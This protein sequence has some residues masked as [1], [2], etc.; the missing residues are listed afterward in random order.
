VAPRREGVEVHLSSKEKLQGRL[1]FN[2]KEGLFDH[3]TPGIP[4]S[5]ELCSTPKS[6]AGTDTTED[7]N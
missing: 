5:K 6:V 2:T 7:V 4:K 1:V 3:R